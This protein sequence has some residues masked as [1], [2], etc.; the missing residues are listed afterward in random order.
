MVKLKQ[1][2][3]R[4]EVLEREKENAVKEGY[5]VKDRTKSK[6]IQ[7]ILKVFSFNS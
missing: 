7:I 3:H 4:E 1:S 2:K 6:F 5:T